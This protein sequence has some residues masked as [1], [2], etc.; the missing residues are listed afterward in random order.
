[1]RAFIW[2]DCSLIKFHAADT[3][4]ASDIKRPL[5][6][7]PKYREQIKYEKLTL[8]FYIFNERCFFKV[9]VK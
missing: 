4:R 8:D 2:F 1:V 5:Y 3:E 7:M 9:E 6:V